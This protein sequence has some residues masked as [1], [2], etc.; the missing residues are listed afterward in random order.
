MFGGVVV[1]LAVVIGVP[2]FQHVMGLAVPN[3]AM[4]ASSAL[5]LAI[6]IVWLEGL[7]RTVRHLRTRSVHAT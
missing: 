2:F 5:M 1:M 7:R 4:L 3:G 6:S